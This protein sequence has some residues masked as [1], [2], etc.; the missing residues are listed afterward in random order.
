[1]RETRISLP[2]LGLIAGTRGML[3]AGLGLLLAD[4][5]PEGQRKGVG[6]TLVIVGILTTIPLALDVLS[7]S[8]AAEAEEWA[9]RGAELSPSYFR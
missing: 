7:A 5:L 4:R 6:W 1:M 3:G 9:D 2:E 8:R